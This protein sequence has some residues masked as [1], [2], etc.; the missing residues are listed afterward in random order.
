MLKFSKYNKNNYNSKFVKIIFKIIRR[1]QN[2]A[3]LIL[4]VIEKSLSIVV[5]V[6]IKY[7]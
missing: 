6:L 3:Y 1:N 4:I 2:K 7:I 5:K